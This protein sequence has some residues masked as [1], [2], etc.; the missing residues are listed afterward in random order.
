MGLLEQQLN[1][2]TQHQITKPLG[3]A[4]SASAG[5]ER[6]GN[7]LEAERFG[8]T[9]IKVLS[10]GRLASRCQ[11]DIKCALR[12][13]CTSPAAEIKIIVSQQIAPHSALDN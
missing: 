9:E 2:F 13:F 4:Y 1:Q 10:V 5:R 11:A 6:R 8:K 12:A 3:G 7:P